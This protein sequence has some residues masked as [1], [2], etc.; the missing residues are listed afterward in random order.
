MDYRKQIGYLK[1]LLAGLEVAENAPENM[2]FRAIVD[3]LDSFADALSD[4][5]EDI[6]ELEDDLQDIS[7]EIGELESISEDIEHLEEQLE[8]LNESISELGSTLYSEGSES[9]IRPL[10]S[11]PLHIV[12]TKSPD[13]ESDDD[14]DEND[15]DDDDDMDDSLSIEDF[16]EEGEEADDCII[17][18]TCPHCGKQVT[19]D[20]DNI[21]IEE[22]PIK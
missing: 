1:G 15:D 2:L 20:D 11:R 21:T 13:D 9:H 4:T 22:K 6:E 18:V 14:D 16:L 10:L 8:H 3:T 19:V 17:L 7:D 12:T 5:K